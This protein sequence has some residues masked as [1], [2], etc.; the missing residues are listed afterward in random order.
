MIIVEDSGA[1][2]AVGIGEGDLQC[3]HGAQDGHQRLDRVAVH[4]WPVLLVVLLSEAALV[5]D[6]APHSE[7]VHDARRT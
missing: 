5:D 7:H 2:L 4:H 3:A 6:P 1:H